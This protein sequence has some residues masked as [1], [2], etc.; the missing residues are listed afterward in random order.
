[1]L[2]DNERLAELL[3]Q[4]EQQAE[5]AH[6]DAA[7]ARAA[8]ADACAELQTRPTPGVPQDQQGAGSAADPQAVA[9]LQAELDREHA[10]RRQVP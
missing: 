5:G 10:L 9:L 8:A 6:C 3:A 7:R 2:Q 1:M 4:A